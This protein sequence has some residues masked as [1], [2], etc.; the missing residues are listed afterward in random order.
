[1][2]S[3]VEE[4]VLSMKF[5]NSNF[6]SN[7]SESMS[8]LDKLKSALKFKGVE[9]GFSKIS[10]AAQK[11][12]M[13][14]LGQAVETVQA[15]FSALEVVA[16]TALANIT[17]KAVDAAESLVKSLTIDQITAG[18]SKYEE[19]MEAVQTIMSATAT[20]WEKDAEAIGFSGTQMEYVSEQLD[21]L[22]WF[23]DETSYSFTDMTSNIGKFTGA[24]QSL[25]DSVT[26]MEGISVWAAKSGQN[27]QT[28]S[29][30]YYNLAQALSVG[31]VKLID[32]RSIENANMATVE[33]KQTAIDTA[34]ALGTLK[35]VKDGLW[36]TTEGT[37]VSVTNFNEALCDEWFTSQVLMDTLNEY[38]KATTLLADYTAETDLSTT[39]LL[40][41]FDSYNDSVTDGVDKTKALQTAAKELGVD[42]EGLGEIFDTLNSEEYELSL[43][44]FRAAQQCKTFKDVIEATKDAISTGWMNTF[45]SLF[46]NY[47]E[48]VEFWSEMCERLWDVFAASGDVRNS[49]LKLWKADGGRDGFIEGIWNLWD[50]MSALMEPF[51]EALND[52][53]PKL[54]SYLSG[55]HEYVEEMAEGFRKI[56][57]AF[58][59]FGTKLQ[60]KLMPYM[61]TLSKVFDGL[62]GVVQGL[63]KIGGSVL[64]NVVD[65]IGSFINRIKQHGIF[66]RAAN[67]IREFGDSFS[68][69]GTAFKNSKNVVPAFFE[70]IKTIGNDVIEIFESLGKVLGRISEK[71]FGTDLVNA[72]GNLMDKLTL[73]LYEGK[74]DGIIA[75]FDKI[76]NALQKINNI[77][78]KAADGLK[79]FFDTVKDANVTGLGALAEGLGNM[80]ASLLDFGKGALQQIGP[81]LQTLGK[82]LGYIFN[83]VGNA[84]KQLNFGKIFSSISALGIA[85]IILKITT[86][87][88][89]LK[90]A[91]RQWSDVHL[92]QIINGVK[93]ALFGLGSDQSLGENILTV[94]KAVGI[95]ALSLW[96]LSSI[97]AGDLAAATGAI[98]AVTAA[99]VG[100]YEMME[101]YNKIE[102]SYASSKQWGTLLKE[103]FVGIA[104]SLKFAIKFKSICTGM[105]LIAAAIKTLAKA[106]KIFNDVE[107]S[108]VEKGIVSAG[109]LVGLIGI[110]ATVDQTGAT[111][112]NGVGLLA[113]A[114]GVKI[115]GKA[116]KIFNEV[117]WGSIWKAD[118][119]T[120]TLG[121]INAALGYFF[122]WSTL[123]GGVSLGVVGGALKE[124]ASGLKAFNDVNWGEFEIAAVSTAGLG[125][126]S[127]IIG[128][129]AKW[130]GLLG[131]ATLGVTGGAM[132]EIAA[133]LKE[134]EGIDWS[135]FDMA[136]ISTAGLGMISTIIGYWG[137]WAGILGGVSLGITGGALKEIASGVDAFSKV[138][139]EE[140]AKASA[141]EAAI[142]VIS[143]LIGGFAGGFAALGGVD[144]VVEGKG[145]KSLAEGVNAFSDVD[146]ISLAKASACEGAIGTISALIGAAGPLMTLGGAG[147][148][149]SGKGLKN[150]ADGINAFSDVKWSELKKAA[151][152]EAAI[153]GISALA[154]AASP[155]MILAGLGT[156]S[157]GKGLEDVGEGLGSLA[158][159]LSEFDKIN[160]IDYDKIAKVVSQ[161]IDTF[162]EMSGL[163]ELIDSTLNAFSA[164]NVGKALSEIAEGL[165]SFNEIG[166]ID[167]YGIKATIIGIR[168]AF[169]TGKDY[170]MGLSDL[171]KSWSDKNVASAF[172][173]MAT[174]LAS[175]GSIDTAALE[176]VPEAITKV[177]ESFS[178]VTSSGWG[179]ELSDLT[180]SWAK[181]NLAKAFQKI[182]TSMSSLADIDT[183]KLYRAI[184]GVEKIFNITSENK[185]Y[186]VQTLAMDLKTL[187]K[188]MQK[189]NDV[190]ITNNQSNMLLR[191]T[192]FMQTA[193]TITN[194]DSV[195]TNMGKVMDAV[196]R[197][198]GFEVKAGSLSTVTEFLTFASSLSAETVAG[199]STGIDTFST[200]LKS[201][202]DNV[203]TVPEQLAG[204]P[205]SLTLVANSVQLLSVSFDGINTTLSGMSGSI[206]TASSGFTE[207]SGTVQTTSSEMQTSVSD[208]VSGMK[209]DLDGIP[210]AATDAMNQFD[211]AL[212]TGKNKAVNTVRSMGS[213]VISTLSTSMPPSS[214]YT[215]GVNLAQGLINGL[216]TKKAAV[217][218]AASALGAA[219]AA[220]VASGG[221]CASPSK[222][223]TQTGIY[224]GEGLLIGMNKMSGKISDSAYSTGNL[225]ATAMNDALSNID[226]TIDSHVPVI[227]PVLDTTYLEKGMNALSR[228]TS[229]SLSGAMGASLGLLQN[230]GSGSNIYNNDNSSVVNYTQNNYSPK[231]LSRKAIYRQT[232][233]QLSRFR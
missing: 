167:Y 29:R 220:A 45:E 218:A 49:I 9:E 40:N 192:S 72:I 91:V 93:D 231:A 187:A 137:K 221:G 47:E 129:Y 189:F 87:I 118:A 77:V 51:H 165:T 186:D 1:M 92:E 16:I 211:A 95:L 227:T 169:S 201:F 101:K 133:G 79:G 89:Q 106:L 10:A 56:T 37:E 122:E 5:D 184:E 48:G 188:A 3:T 68:K 66:D 225:A 191:I 180:D 203:Q 31:S 182:A 121:L 157:I 39:E 94:A 50:A 139:W 103:Q 75:F 85:G 41:T 196:K 90:N 100:M 193:S 128:Y 46:G 178:C 97:P 158:N 223:T 2:S 71:I 171:V 120:F 202:A 70:G 143:T 132:K 233:S 18:Y 42:A 14:P 17:N 131:G 224:M 219:A 117:D 119:A 20:T 183:G 154:G 11:V 136:A 6:E 4:R 26:A 7:V 55:S 150:L 76:H 214:A 88:T 147:L 52:H 230:G 104:E 159:G 181:G 197:L 166:D 170:G 54:E 124:M 161:V 149:T 162:A 148:S 61:E 134:F 38:G 208:A 156:Q 222:L 172:Q 213:S 84:I 145:L 13:S 24:G 115:L 32:W 98:S 53:F 194:L 107:W 108:S 111:L 63:G 102:Q 25:T 209:E 205:E 23:S 65:L 80:A 57:D 86:A 160:K 116:L 151:G 67:A 215:V 204:I 216:N 135:A 15:K 229:V 163:P 199:L 35:K 232:K 64:S 59:E 58:S 30:A 140:F 179:Y 207:L 8:T 125:M 28:A 152:C 96:V 175:L 22:N 99:I 138:S 43:S 78:G 27:A 112:K 153:A 73:K 164:Q 33:F 155:L 146:W 141:C 62:L 142:G 69:L 19:K 173:T 198:N 83:T 206:T 127:S 212:V 123:I 36:K 113:A 177:L 185:T 168:D 210:D 60:T 195:A 34:E 74:A 126:I 176:G 12:E 44:A 114:E 174:S 190:D 109:S 130:S 82:S 226:T 105:I 217:T 228:S 200:S 144:M 21:K 81:L 110:L